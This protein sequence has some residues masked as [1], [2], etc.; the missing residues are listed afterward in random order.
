MDQIRVPGCR[1]TARTP[2][3]FGLISS[4]PLQPLHRL[5]MGGLIVAEVDGTDDVES[6]VTFILNPP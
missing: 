3:V 2:S 1:C 5:L 6:L 4:A